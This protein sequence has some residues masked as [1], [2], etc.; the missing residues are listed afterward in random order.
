M[1]T[2]AGIELVKKNPVTTA[3]VA[4]CRSLPRFKS[5]CDDA[6]GKRDEY[7]AIVCEEPRAAR[8]FKARVVEIDADES[9][10]LFNRDLNFPF[11]KRR[12]GERV[13]T[14]EK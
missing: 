12:L 6:R 14:D 5:L 1:V 8:V 7:R 13:I 11:H 2:E 9:A 10:S 3:P 4:T